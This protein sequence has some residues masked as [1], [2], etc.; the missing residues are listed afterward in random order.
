MS[1]EVIALNPPSGDHYGYA[2]PDWAREH[3]H[4]L[5]RPYPSALYLNVRSGLEWQAYREDSGRWYMRRERKLLGGTGWFRFSRTTKA[6]LEDERRWRY[7]G[8]TPKSHDLY[9]Y[10]MSDPTEYVG[11][12]YRIRGY[13]ENR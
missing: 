8:P 13:R 9:G 12:R 5:R 1:S 10:D 2:Y 7:L 11:E 6:A 3:E 4:A